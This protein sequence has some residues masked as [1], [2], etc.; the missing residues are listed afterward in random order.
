MSTELA[1]ILAVL[2]ETFGTT[3]EHLWGVIVRQKLTEGTMYIV[4]PG[5]LLMLLT[6]LVRHIFVV[7]EEEPD[8]TLAAFSLAGF[9][10]IVVLAAIAIPLGV[11]MILNPE[12]YALQEILRAIGR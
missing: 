6:L 10:V 11:L 1:Q 3:V 7:S 5:T 12:Y 8:E 9:V 4:V 2:S